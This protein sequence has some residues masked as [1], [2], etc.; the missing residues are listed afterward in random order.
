M[1]IGLPAMVPGYDSVYQTVSE[2]GEVG[3]PAQL[4]FTLS[5]CAIGLCLAVF[6]WALREAAV[7]LGRSS[8]PVWLT[9]CMAV[10]SAGVGI[11][12]FPYA[13]HNVFGT[14]EIIGYQAPLV[15]ALTWR[16]DARVRQIVKTSWIMG[17]LVWV[18]IGLNCAVFDPHGALWVFERPFYG[19]VQRSLFVTWFIWAALIGILLAR[20]AGEQPSIPAP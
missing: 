14:S 17:A 12:S 2:I 1:V 9:V 10:S 7:R 13:L 6:A 5:L 11:F 18:S 16:G 20:K 8:A 4:P 15:L 19:L 3:S